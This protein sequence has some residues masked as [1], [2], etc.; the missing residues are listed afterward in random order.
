MCWDFGQ[1]RSGPRL[2]TIR[3]PEDAD[4]PR[5]AAHVIRFARSHPDHVGVGRRDGH[6][7]DRSHPHRIEHGGPRDAGIGGFVDAAGGCGDVDHRTRAACARRR[8]ILRNRNVDDAAAHECRA[9]GPELERSY[10]HRVGRQVVGWAR[11]VR[12]APGSRSG[13]AIGRRWSGVRRALLGHDRNGQ[14][15]W[16]AG[17][18]ERSG[19]ARHGMAANGNGRARRDPDSTLSS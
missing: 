17:G 9:D 13:R 15:N 10:Q 11:A 12:A 14:E 6:G 8:S 3:G 16:S 4:A 19:K 1:H 7:T 18:D 5:R 2:A